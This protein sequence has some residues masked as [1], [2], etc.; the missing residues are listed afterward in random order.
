MIKPHYK[1][2]TVAPGEVSTQELHGYLLSAVAPRP[3]AF[4]STVDKE[5]NVNLSPFS[6]FNVFSANPPTLI[7]SPARRVRNN[8]TK[9]TLENILET[10]EVVINVVT[11]EIVHQASLASTEYAED[12]NEFIKAGLTEVKSDIVAPPR[13]LESKVS[14]ECKVNDVISLGNEGGAGNL[15]ICE[16]LKVHIHEEVLDEDGRI[17]T[18]RMKLVARMGGSWYCKAFG[19]ALFQIPKPLQTLGVGFDHLPK[20]ILK[21]EVLT[22]NDLAQL[23]NVEEIPNGVYSADVHDHA[24]A[25]QLLNNGKLEEAWQAL[26]R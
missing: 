7:F 6:F 16:V 8:T 26:I 10:K 9:H 17:S 18:E 3:I 20:D 1:I 22:G 5:G 24:R 13:V 11:E 15:I 25:K 23:A 21:S 4:A 2:K 12:V 14:I 19:D